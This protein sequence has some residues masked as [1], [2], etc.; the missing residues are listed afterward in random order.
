M[1]TLGLPEGIS[2]TTKG[3]KLTKIRNSFRGLRALRGGFSNFS[4]QTSQTNMVVQAVKQIMRKCLK[5]NCLQSKIC[6]TQSGSVK[7]SQT[8]LLFD[9]WP[10]LLKK[11]RL[12]YCGLC[13]FLSV[14]IRVHPWLKLLFRRILTFA[15]RCPNLLAA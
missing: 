15:I 1:S 7:P 5:M 10:K 3:T 9:L 2:F 12:H 11:S 13:I 4:G 8:D 6:Q 14:L